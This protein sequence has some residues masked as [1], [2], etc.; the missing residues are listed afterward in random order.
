MRRSPCPSAKPAYHS[1]WSARRAL[2]AVW[3]RG[4]HSRAVHVY[5][6]VCGLWH[7]GRY[8]Q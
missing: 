1:Y 6:C 4:H 2:L 3:R 5:R 8:V 7:L